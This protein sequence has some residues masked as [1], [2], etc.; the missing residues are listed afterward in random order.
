M[1]KKIALLFVC[2]ICVT[3]SGCS[4]IRDIVDSYDNAP[5]EP[6]KMTN[7]SQYTVV[8]SEAEIEAMMLQTMKDN[9]TTCYFNVA[10]EK[11]I[12]ADRWVKAFD[13]IN[14][15]DVEYTLAQ[16]GYNVF[17]TLDYWDN[18]PIIAAF[19]KNDT[20]ILNATQLELFDKYCDILG[21]C[22]SKSYTPYENE[23]A[24]HDY[25]VSNVSYSIDP[26]KGRTAYDALIKQSAVCSGYAESFKTLLDMLGI[27]NRVI[28]GT[29][30]GEAHGWN[31]V[32]LDE[33]WYHVDVTWDDPV[34]GDGSI[35]HKY[36]NVTDADMALD[37]IWE[38]GEYPLATGNAY[39]YHVMSGMAQ[40][41]SQAE[42]DAFIREKIASGAEKIEFIMY[43]PD[44]DI[45]QALQAAS[46]SLGGTGVAMNVS[47]NI[48][49]K[50]QFSMYD[51]T[52]EYK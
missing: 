37:H 12:D 7:E 4:K 14:S 50:T 32:N 28:K 39:A 41:N 2:A 20:T 3:V 49:K 21:T 30:N 29:A 5:T 46:Q 23:L 34:N 27:E 22:T 16:S 52:I 8:Q 15:V 45:N 9:K 36:F 42:L 1:Y 35:S 38:Y 43:G 26:D 44:I 40:L 31:L 13:G 18:Y 33:E 48:T 24:I 19:E 47:Y 51:I 11:M 6:V 17:V 10:D 25:L